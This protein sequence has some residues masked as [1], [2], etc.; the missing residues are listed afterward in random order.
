MYDQLKLPDPLLQGTRNGVCEFCGCHIEILKKQAMLVIQ[1]ASFAPFLTQY[2]MAAPMPN[3]RMPQ[4]SQGMAPI[5][6][7]QMS[8]VQM[9]QAQITQAQMSQS[10][11]SHGQMTPMSQGEAS[12]STSHKRTPVSGRSRPL[13]CIMRSTVVLYDDFISYGKAFQIW[14]VPLFIL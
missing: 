14:Q 6:Q 9:S 8:Q 12:N 10:Q 11:M 4:I 1:S 2:M 5:S 13:N 3:Q 7:T